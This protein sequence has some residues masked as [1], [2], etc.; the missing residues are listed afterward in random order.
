MRT[1]L[2][3]DGLCL[4]QPERA[5]TLPFASEFAPWG[6]FSDCFCLPG[7]PEAQ[8]RWK[9]AGLR[10]HPVRSAAERRTSAAGLKRVFPATCVNLSLW[11]TAPI[12][13]FSFF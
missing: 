5:S 1:L 3:K 12:Q 6:F 7:Q 4:Q 11:K 8:S 13:D 9:E 2:N 10:V